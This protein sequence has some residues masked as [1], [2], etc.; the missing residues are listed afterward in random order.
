M[1]HHMRMINDNCQLLKLLTL[2]I[3]EVNVWIFFR[4]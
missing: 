2:Y 3:I 1:T 4:S